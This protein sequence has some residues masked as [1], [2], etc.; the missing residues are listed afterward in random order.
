MG[1]YPYPAASQQEAVAGRH[2]VGAKVGALD[3]PEQRADATAGQLPQL[4]ALQAPATR[5]RSC[6]CADGVT[7]VLTSVGVG[8]G[9]ES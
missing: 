2:P 4:S 1:N 5:Q 6:F 7:R 3:V 8:V 9:V